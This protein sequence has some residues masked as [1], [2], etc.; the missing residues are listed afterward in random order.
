MFCTVFPLWYWRREKLLC[1]DGFCSF[2]GFSVSILHAG[3]IMPGIHEERLA[4]L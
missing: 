3:D 1:P 2:L 4:D